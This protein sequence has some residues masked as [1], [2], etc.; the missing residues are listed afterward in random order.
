MNLFAFIRKYD[1]IENE[2]N[3]EGSFGFGIDC[4]TKGWQR[5]ALRRE[6]NAKEPWKSVNSFD[7]VEWLESNKR[8]RV[9]VSLMP[10][11]TVF[12]KNSHFLLCMLN[13]N[14]E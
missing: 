13:I 1:S 3:F 2:V 14:F 7:K 4:V 11:S 6:T 8:D 9:K 10:S 5:V 12:K